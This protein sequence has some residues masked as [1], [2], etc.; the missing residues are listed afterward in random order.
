MA[1]LDAVKMKLNEMLLTQLHVVFSNINGKDIASRMKHRVQSR[2][3]NTEVDRGKGRVYEKLQDFST[4]EQLKCILRLDNS[5]TESNGNRIKSFYF[6]EV[7]EN[8]ENMN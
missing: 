8:D 4:N 3:E 6:D 5:T 1:C 7:L 2:A